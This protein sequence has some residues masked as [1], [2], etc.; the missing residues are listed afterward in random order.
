[1]IFLFIMGISI[2][3]LNNAPGTITGSVSINNQSITLKS[4]HV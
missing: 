3:I 4:P 1:M 2:F